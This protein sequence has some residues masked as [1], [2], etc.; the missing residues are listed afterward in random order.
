MDS[1]PEKKCLAQ[2][3]LGHCSEC[4]SLADCR[5]NSHD[6]D[7]ARCNLG[8]SADEITKGVLPYYANERSLRM[9]EKVE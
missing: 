7:P 3:G 8:I 6:F 5:I 1:C 9:K 2:K 4:G